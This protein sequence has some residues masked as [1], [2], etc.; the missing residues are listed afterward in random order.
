MGIDLFP[1]THPRRDNRILASGGIEQTDGALSE[2]WRSHRR[3]GGKMLALR[4]GSSDRHGR[5]S[6]LPHC[7]SRGVDLR[8]MP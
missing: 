8:A 2:L 6:A 7:G 3:G 5:V 1:G 4:Y